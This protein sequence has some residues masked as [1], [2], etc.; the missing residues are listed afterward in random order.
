MPCVGQV[1]A[2]GDDRGFDGGAGGGDVLVGAVCGVS[3]RV[4]LGRVVMGAGRL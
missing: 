3:G 4:V 2:G 1:G